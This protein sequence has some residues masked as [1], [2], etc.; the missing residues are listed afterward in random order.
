MK[1]GKGLMLLTEVRPNHVSHH[2]VI[3]QYTG[4]LR[5]LYQDE[6]GGLRLQQRC[7]VSDIEA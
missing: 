7:T 6:S 2:L 5:R 3:G 1:E 4:P